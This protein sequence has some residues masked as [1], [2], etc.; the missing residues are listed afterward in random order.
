MSGRKGRS[1]KVYPYN[2]QDCEIDT[3]EKAEI[4]KNFFASV[5]NGCLSISL[6]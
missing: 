4:L 5:L 3:D 1:E 6:E 2:K